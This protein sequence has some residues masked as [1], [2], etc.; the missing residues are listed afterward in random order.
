MKPHHLCADLLDVSVSPRRTAFGA[1]CLLVAAL[2]APAT[3]GVLVDPGPVTLVSATTVG[4]RPIGLLAAGTDPAPVTPA[5]RDAL[6]RRVEGA[7]GGSTAVTLSAAVDV[8]GYDAVLRRESGHPLPP[9]STQKS[10]VGLSALVALGPSARLRTEVARTATPVGGVLSGNLWLVAGG[11]PYLTMPGLRALARQVR[12]AGI[13]RVTGDVRLDDSRY[14]GRRTASGWKSSYMPGQSGPLSALAVDRNR[15]RRDSAFLSDPAL[16]AAVRF[17][18]YLRAEGVSVGAVRRE[19]RPADAV[20]VAER[21][22]GPVPAVV[23]RALKD[24]DNFAAELLLKEVGRVVKDDGSSA[25]GLAAVREV[26]GKQGVPLGASSDGSGLSRDNRQTT[27]GQVLM[28]RAA[29][30]SGSGPAFR[31][32]LPLGCRDGTLKRR[33]CGTAAEGRVSAKTGT[34]TGVRALSGYTRT[35]SGRSVW[36][37]FQLTGV[38]D[39]SKALAAIDRAVVVLASST[40]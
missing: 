4:P 25:G 28:L 17:R 33:Y 7:L 32:S 16:P 38:K 19:R 9:A 1:A 30:D 12:E 18:D 14:D 22:S 40:D 39:G 6:R 5:Q 35:A 31:A 11:D 3:A 13:T 23:R 37:A 10:Y 8:D 27:S 2:G 29:D 34:L 26:L 24:S 15:W 21:L 20:T 36:F